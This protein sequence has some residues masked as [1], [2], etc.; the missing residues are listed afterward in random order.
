[1]G[2]YTY[3]LVFLGQANSACPMGA[4][5]STSKT[6]FHR[7]QKVHVNEM[8]FIVGWVGVAGCVHDDNLWLL[9]IQLT[10]ELWE[11]VV[12]A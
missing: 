12:Y 11:S 5:F 7:G 2:G 1:M 9:T 8:C 4:Q 6:H 10:F 3:R